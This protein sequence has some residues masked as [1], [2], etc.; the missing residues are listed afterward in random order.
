MRRVLIGIC[1]CLLQASCARGPNVTS[2]QLPLRRVVVYRNGVAYYER[3]GHVDS[4]EVKFRMRQHLVGD[5]LA[6]LAIVETGGS[7]VRSASFPIK[8]ADQLE[9]R[10]KEFQELLRADLNGSSAAEEPACVK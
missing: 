8:V 4:H 6:T 10:A 9:P 5:F 1:A 7:R 2:G 3:A